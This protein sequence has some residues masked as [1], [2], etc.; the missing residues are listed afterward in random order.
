MKKNEIIDIKKLSKI[1]FKRKVTLNN[2]QKNNN[3]FNN[4][5]FFILYLF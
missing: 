4:Y 2:T 1:K 5:V 3:I